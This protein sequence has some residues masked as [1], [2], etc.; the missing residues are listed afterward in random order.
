MDILTQAGLS[1]AT[2]IVVANTLT[3]LFK[4]IIPAE[5][6]F[7]GNFV[8]LMNFGFS[9]LVAL[10]LA[11]VLDI[12]TSETFTLLVSIIGAIGSETVHNTN[13]DT[14]IEVYEGE[15]M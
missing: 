7:Y 2:I 14:V 13:D 4:F 8:R 5:N 15:D 11:S 9:I 10:G 12:G 1:I 6:K 3:N